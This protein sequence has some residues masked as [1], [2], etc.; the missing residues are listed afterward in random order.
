MSVQKNADGSITVGCLEDVIAPKK[1]EP[2]TE[3][4]K[5]AGRKPKA[6]PVVEDDEVIII[7]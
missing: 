3:A 2:K 4:P 1:V 5:K 6:K 7:E